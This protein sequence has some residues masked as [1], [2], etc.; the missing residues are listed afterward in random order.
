VLEEAGCRVTSIA[1]C[2]Y[3][4]F[5]SRN[6]FEKVRTRLRCALEGVLADSS[7]RRPIRFVGHNLNLGKN[8]A[9]SAAFADIA[10]AQAAVG[11]DVRFYSVVHD[12]FEE[13]RV[14]MLRVIQ[15]LEHQGVRM[16]ELLYPA[17]GGAMTFVTPSRS[18]ATRLSR[19]GLVAK[20][21]FNP[22]APA[23]ISGHS[24]R[25]KKALVQSCQ[26]ERIAFRPSC[27]VTFYPMRIIARKN[28]VEALLVAPVLM[29]SNL[30]LGAPGT[31]R[32]DLLLCERMQRMCA[33]L[34]LPVVFDVGKWLGAFAVDRTDEPLSFRSAYA[35]ADLCLSTSVLEGFGYALYEPW[36]HD[37][38]LVGR[39]PQGFSPFAGLPFRHLYDALL[40]PIDWAG[41]RSFRR[42]LRWVRRS[43]GHG[44]KEGDEILRESERTGLVDFALLG[45]AQQFDILYRVAS[46]PSLAEAIFFS[47]AG[48]RE[49]ARSLLSAVETGAI[50]SLVAQ[51]RDAIESRLSPVDFEKAFRAVFLDTWKGRGGNNALFE[52]AG[53]RCDLTGALQL[54]P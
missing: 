16:A 47:R 14:D 54:L 18:T 5:R 11:D 23:P 12:R 53:S 45:H 37:V 44:V 10:A 48:R 43:T 50:R 7:L 39:R 34:E 2:D 28:P 42:R 31:S 19:S 52:P 26:R 9:L 20:V 8:C 27:P 1:D 46:Q 21:L 35:A 13:G 25:V 29:G 6:A 4:L 33:E 22:V 30:L 41:G 40:V 49:S 24:T 3:R 38:P 15:G 32:T 36:L 17:A 51:Y